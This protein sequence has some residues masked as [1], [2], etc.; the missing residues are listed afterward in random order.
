MVTPNINE[1]MIQRNLALRF[2]VGFVVVGFL[3][4]SSAKNGAHE[5]VIV[6]I[7]QLPMV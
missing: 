5:P 1:R 7:G 3:F 4:S 6:H 2:P